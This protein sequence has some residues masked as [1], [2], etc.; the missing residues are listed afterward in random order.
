M[1][2]RTV[3]AL[4]DLRVAESGQRFVVISG[5]PIG[6]PGSTNMVQVRRVGDDG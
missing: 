6:R 3:Q 2:D 5:Q 4:S 1:M